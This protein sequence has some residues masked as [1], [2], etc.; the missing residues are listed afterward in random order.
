[1]ALSLENVFAE[2]IC[3]G[4]HV[5]PAA[6]EV[7]LKS[8]GTDETVL[9]TDCMRA[10]GQGEG[11]SRLGEFEVVVKD[12]AARLKHNGSLAGSILELIQA[13]QH[14]VEWNLAT[15]PNALRMASLA[16]ARSVGIDHICGQ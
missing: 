4:H 1:A 7:V 11:D 10:G 2:V 9:I 16:P 3:D 12:G 6:V 13:V 5:H 14:L 15:L 8:R